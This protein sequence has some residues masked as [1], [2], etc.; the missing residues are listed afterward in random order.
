MELEAVRH[1]HTER[2][3]L[4]VQPGDDARLLGLEVQEERAIVDVVLVP[5]DGTR[6]CAIGL[7]VLQSAEIVGLLICFTIQLL[8][9]TIE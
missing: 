5:E 4:Q 6:E 8:C 1:S 2:L 9:V 3:A 7:F